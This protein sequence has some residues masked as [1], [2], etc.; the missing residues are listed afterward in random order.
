MNEAQLA[1][2]RRFR[3]ASIRRRPV[4][5]ALVHTMVCKGCELRIRQNL[6]GGFAARLYDGVTKYAEGIGPTLDGALAAAFV[7]YR[8]RE[9][10]CD[11]TAIGDAPHASDCEVW[12][13]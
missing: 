4:L 7:G 1:P 10:L 3:C 2:R 13:P 5:L 8:V 6:D 12:A 11:C 9:K